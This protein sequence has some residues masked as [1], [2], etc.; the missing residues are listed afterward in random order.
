M[1]SQR[2][3]P[4]S[5]LCGLEQVTE[6]PG[7]H[8]DGSTYFPGL[9]TEFTGVFV[10]QQDQCLLHSSVHVCENGAGKEPLPPGGHVAQM[11]GCIGRTRSS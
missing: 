5:R 1:Q 3:S 6:L 4:I 10:K 8:G 11:Q 9:L 2:T 7:E